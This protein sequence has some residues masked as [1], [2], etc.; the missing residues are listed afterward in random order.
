M[1]IYST[2]GHLS[3]L[4]RVQLGSFY[5]PL[6][7]VR[8]CHQLIKPYVSDC[9]IVFDNA[10]G[11]GAFLDGI[12]GSVRAA[13]S[14]GQAFDVLCRHHA[15]QDL[16]YGNALLGVR[17]QAYAIGD[18]DFLIMVGNP[19]YNDITSSY[20]KGQK[21]GHECDCVLVDRDKGISFMRSYDLLK[22]HVVCVLHPL[23]YL[24]KEANFLRLKG[25]RQNY[26]LIRGE[27][28]SSSWFTKASS[29][30]PIVLGLYERDPRG[31][32]FDFIRSFSF[33][34]L[35]N[36]KSWRLADYTTTDGYINKYPP[37]L[38][39]LKKS[40]LGLYYYSFRDINSLKRNASFMTSSRNGIVVTVENFYRYAYLHCFKRLF[41]RDDMWLLGNLSPL[42]NLAWLENNKATCVSWAMQDSDVLRGLPRLSRSSVADY[43]NAMYTIPADKRSFIFF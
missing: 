28:F 22:A 13:E 8:R 17:R 7:I 4:E 43:Y 29:Q 42:V 27:L 11:F 12:D 9:S 41:K 23:S 1:D 32:D 30:F 20:K 25:F 15:R 19:P 3:T 38:H 5:T 14:D 33:S 18:D 16:F 10:A 34:F 21:G 36:E 6:P 31:M 40:P 24:I 2:A 39:E 37:R 26:R 35:E